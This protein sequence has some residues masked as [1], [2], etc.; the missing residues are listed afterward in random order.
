M[1]LLHMRPKWDISISRFYQNFAKRMN[2][3]LQLFL[4]GLLGIDE[5]VGKK[6]GPSV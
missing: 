2:D 3:R 5:S 6:Y 1:T 4:Y